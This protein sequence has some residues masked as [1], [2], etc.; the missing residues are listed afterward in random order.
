MTP[1]E[2]YDKAYWASKNPRIVAMRDHTLRSEKLERQGAFQTLAIELRN[3]GLESQGDLI[4]YPIMVDH[5]G[6][7][8]TMV[9]IRK[10]AGYTWVPNALQQ[11]IGHVAMYPGEEPGIAVPGVPPLPG[12]SAY[13]PDNPPKGSILVLTDAAEYKPYQAAD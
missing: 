13:D 1:E 8:R 2:T 6:P 4:D 9:E 10:P 11:P 12:Q 3:E 7:Y 5:F